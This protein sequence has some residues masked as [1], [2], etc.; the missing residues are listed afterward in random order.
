MK[1]V[2][3]S[4]MFFICCACVFADEVWEP[5]PGIKGPDVKEI[6]AN[7]DL[8]YAASSKRL[9]LSED[10]GKTWDVVFLARG[11]DAAINFVDIFKNAVYVSTNKGL[12][13]SIDGKSGWKNVFKGIGVEKNNVRHI[14]FLNR[15]IYLGTE[16][17]LFISNDSGAAWQKTFDAS[18]KWIAFSE[19]DVFLATEKGVYKTSGPDW[20]RVFITSTEEI[21]YN[22]DS[23]DESLSALNPV[24]SILAANDKI[25]LSTDSGIFISY[26][27]GGSWLRFE[28]AGLGSEKIN[29]ILFK[30]DLYAATDSGVFVF[31]D[32][33]KIWQA[34]YK[35]ISTDRVNAIACDDKGIMWVATDKGLY[36]SS[37]LT[38]TLSPKGRGGSDYVLELF[39][40]ET[41]VRQVQEV[42]IKYAEVNPDK[43]KN[44]RRR[45]KIKAFFPEVSVD[46]DKTINYDGGA[47]RYYVGPHD[48][49]ASVKWDLGEI[50]WNPDQTS[51]DVRSKLMGQL[52]DDILGEGCSNSRH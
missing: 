4:A 42:A 3:I 16:A 18:I 50:I 9:Y 35:G 14:A 17:G 31:N 49:G 52:R 26:D 22:T 34:L 37:P 13:R 44:W 46:Y 6:V 2:L 27:K 36:K 5:V 11:E 8:F 43:I 45:A 10:D 47:D 20:K 40:N 15:E 33:D 32:N 51:I 38:L 21:E 23:Q 30:D 48:W 1:I 19:K 28:S 41:S 25:Y 7:G 12:F 39:E 29:R 24:N